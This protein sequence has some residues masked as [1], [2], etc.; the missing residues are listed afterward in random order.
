[1][2][3]GYESDAE[4][5]RS[6]RATS[7]L[8]EEADLVLTAEAAHRAY[9][10]EETPGAFRKVF[11]LGQF[12]EA[13][14]ALGEDAPRGRALIDAIGRHRTQADPRHDV[15]DPYRKGAEAGRACAVRIDELLGVVLPA[16]RE[17]RVTQ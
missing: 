8:V 13:V 17:T 5:F 4:S 6:R 14:A 15:A 7:A 9:L 12:A 2:I 1:M 3:A 16:L 11:T 10:L